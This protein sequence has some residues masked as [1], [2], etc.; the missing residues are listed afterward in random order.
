[1]RFHRQCLGIEGDQFILVFNIDENGP[2]AVGR[3][4][5]RLAAQRHGAGHAARGRVN[6]GGIVAAAVEREDAL[7]EGIV[8]DTV[9]PRADRDLRELL[10]A[11]AVDHGDL[12]GTAFADIGLAADEGGAVNARQVGDV[13]QHFAG[14]GI[15]HHH[16]IAA[17]DIEIACCRISVQVI[18]PAIAAQRYGFEHM[19]AGRSSRGGCRK[20]GRAGTCGQKPIT[21]RTSCQAMHISLQMFCPYCGD[22]RQPGRC[23]RYKFC[24]C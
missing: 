3:G 4:R 15:H 19:V 10:E 22:E 24:Q 7:G 14:I 23:L 16:M 9:G 5:L 17:G 21:R 11:L 1:M 8:E 6:R 12:V 20:Q 13:G 2:R 18:E